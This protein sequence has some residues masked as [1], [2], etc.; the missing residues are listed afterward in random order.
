MTI[1]PAE[2]A[3]LHQFATTTTLPRAYGQPLGDA[4]F[5]CSPEDFQVEEFTGIEPCGTG[6]HVYVRIRKTG[7]NTRWV[8]KQLAEHLQLPYKSVSYAGMKDRHAITSQ[9]FS[10]HMPGL[11]MPDLQP[12]ALAGCEIID[13]A[14][15]D[16]KLRPGQ[17]SYNRFRIVL[18]DCVIADQ[19]ELNERIASLTQFGLPNYFGS[20]R[21][22]RAQGNLDLADDIRKLRTL[23]RDQR[24]FFLSATR[25]ALFNGYLAGRVQA[26]SWNQQLAGEVLLSDRPRGT[27]ETDTSVFDGER[28]PSGLLW[29]K[30][31]SN[32]SGD[33]LA[34]EQAFFAGFPDVTR[35][36]ELA[37]SRASRRVLRLRVGE[38]T[39][40]QQ[41]DSLELNFCL[42]PGGYA[43][44][45]LQELFRLQ[46]RVSDKEHG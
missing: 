45:L 10:A 9:W 22:G 2:S 18:R 34:Y 43:T 25:G 17:L 13:V 3:E 26:E 29:G 8:A 14:R 30:G 39:M 20:Q 42:G 19:V 41:G 21:F 31:T 11:E 1:S 36:L 40:Q 24:A 7:E 28:Q 5:R 15:H 37:G 23:N 27:A 4:A 32:A 46:D 16:R 12:D 6:E 33:A 35:L 38:L 44:T